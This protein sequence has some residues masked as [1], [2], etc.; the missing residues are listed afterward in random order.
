MNDF[1]CVEME[2]SLHDAPCVVKRVLESKYV[3]SGGGTVEAALSYTLKTTKNSM[4][5]WEQ[6]TLAEFAGY[7]LVILAVNAVQNSTDMVAKLRASQKE[8]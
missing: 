5:P 8:A 7:I 6:L 2:H 4:G 3:I 1:M